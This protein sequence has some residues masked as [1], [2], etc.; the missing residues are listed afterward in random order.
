MDSGTL[1]LVFSLGLAW[2][3]IALF[4]KTVVSANFM[5]CVTL[6]GAVA[7]IILLWKR[8]L[9]SMNKFFALVYCSAVGGGTLYFLFL[10]LNFAF[11]NPAKKT[12]EFKVLESGTLAKG[13]S[14]C[15]NPF[16][17]IDFYG[18]KKQL[19]FDCRYGGLSSASTIVLEYKRGLFGFEYIVRQDRKAIELLE[20]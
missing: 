19:I 12:G 4:R 10:F 15:N 5:W 1:L 7:G 17:I 13:K 8:C 6:V 18:S 16:V 2:M 11:V 3:G 9:S 14:G 20:Q